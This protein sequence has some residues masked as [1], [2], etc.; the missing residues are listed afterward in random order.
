M[1]SAI[2]SKWDAVVFA[3]WFVSNPDLPE[4][5]RLGKLLH[6]Y[7]R[8]RFYGSWDGVRERGYVDYPTWQEEAAENTTSQ[9][10]G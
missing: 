3:K 1:T 6:A 10:K 2:N 5:L 8:S 7:D 9:V 4:R